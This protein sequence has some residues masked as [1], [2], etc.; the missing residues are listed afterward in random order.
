M[1]R[2]F[3]VALIVLFIGFLSGT[4]CGFSTYEQVHGL[5]KQEIKE[6]GIDSL[7]TGDTVATVEGEK[8]DS[9]KYVGVIERKI[10]QANDKDTE[11]IADLTEKIQI[12]KTTDQ[13]INARNR[14]FVKVLVGN[15]N[16]ASAKEMAGIIE[17]IG[18][19][20]KVIDYAPV[21]RFSRDTV[22]YTAGS[23]EKAEMIAARLGENTIVKPITWYS[24]FD[25]IAVT[26]GR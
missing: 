7:R 3:L 4:F 25:I 17:Q 1:F 6:R 22:F 9:S 21:Q 13:K 15:K 8:A 18:Y 2:N 26:G 10:Q 19:P 14:I 5:S 12:P 11:D 20:V 24:V 23:K 16:M